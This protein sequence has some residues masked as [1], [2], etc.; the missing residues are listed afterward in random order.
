V[1]RD[2][3]LEISRN[4]L[5]RRRDSLELKQDRRS[6]SRDGR[7][8]STVKLSEAERDSALIQY[9]KTIQM[10]FTEV[11][12]A[13]IARQ[14]T[15]E[16]RLEQEKLVSALQDR[17]RSSRGWAAGG[18]D[19]PT[20]EHLAP[21][22]IVVCLPSSRTLI[23][24][25]F[26]H[27]FIG[28]SRALLQAG[29]LM[30]NQKLRYYMH[31]GP[32]AFRFELAGELNQEGARQL[33]QDW[34]TASSMIGDRR[35]NIDMT[36]VTAV[37]EYGKA[38]LTRWRRE[39][40]KIIANSNASRALAESILG[41]SI[42]ECAKDAALGPASNQ[43]W[44]PFR[45]SILAPTAS[46][47]A[48]LVALLFP[49]DAFAATLRSDTIA[50][51]DA[52]LHGANATFQD[53]VRPGGP[54]LWTLQDAERAAK[55]RS[56]EIV[57]ASANGDNPQ[58]VPGGLIHHWIGAVFLPDVKLTDTVELT[59]DYDRFKEFYHPSVFESKAIARD[60]SDDI[61][62]MQLVNKVF[63]SKT[64]LDADYRA[65]NVRVD[66]RRF[67]RVSKTTRV[68][69][70][71]DFG[72]PGEHRLPEGEG[73]GYIWKLYSVARFEQRDGGVYVELEAIALSRDIPV[74]VRLVAAPIVRRISRNSLLISLQ[75]TEQAV[76]G[77]VAVSRS[78]SDPAI[79]R[80]VGDIRQTLL[81]K[82]TAFTSVH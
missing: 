73:G 78:A 74:A 17:T 10:A 34:R 75:Q 5:K 30:K 82:S 72:Q 33:D 51:W 67:Y 31:D 23:F 70:V 7:L 39:G 2:Y 9:E 41:E 13:L 58:R 69:E 54:F 20:A 32:A 11:S 19:R 52:Y 57:V 4:T 21:A 42:S 16:S 77:G 48:L 24:V 76:R 80:Q 6:R 36:F 66:D 53:R 81:N 3:E 43:T 37:D 12:N 40:A 79:A 15:H 47:L 60:G 59:R 18:N 1:Q 25:G 61:F 27:E 71:E 44:R 49:A 56:G 50:A 63:F 65:T 26:A 45:S 22:G 14:R 38:L 55:V 28:S 64:A 46:F 68:Q 8:E 62:S 29:I 35:L